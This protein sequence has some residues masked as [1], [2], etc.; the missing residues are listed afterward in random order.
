MFKMEE[1]YYL[2]GI[3]EKYNTRELTRRIVQPAVKKVGE[4]DDFFGL[5]Y[6]YLKK[7]SKTAGIVFQWQGKAEPKKTKKLIMTDYYDEDYD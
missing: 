6:S 3:P 5:E 2:L 4:I 1:F 7:G